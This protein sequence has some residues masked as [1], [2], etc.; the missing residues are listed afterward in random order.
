[1]TDGRG[2]EGAGGRRVGARVGWL[3]LE[4][5]HVWWILDSVSLFFPL[6]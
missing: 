6:Q 5:L 1:M 4:S 2:R 3:A